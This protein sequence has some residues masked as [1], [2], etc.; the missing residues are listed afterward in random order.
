MVKGAIS[1]IKIS[2]TRSSRPIEFNMQRSTHV[3][4]SVEKW[5]GGGR[6][7]GK[8]TATRK[9]RILPQSLVQRFLAKFPVDDAL[10]SESSGH[11][12]DATIR[13]WVKCKIN[14]QAFSSPSGDLHF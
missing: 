4:S 11:A 12:T 10:C 14:L 2:L 6:G 1:K 8:P 7:G 13:I 5:W 3:N 9:D